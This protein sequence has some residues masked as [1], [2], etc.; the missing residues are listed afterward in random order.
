MEQHRVPE[1]LKTLFEATNLLYT[2][3]LNLKNDLVLEQEKVK[4]GEIHISQEL[5]KSKYL[6]DSLKKKLSS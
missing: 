2:E 6:I 1:C 3:N 4:K 5:D